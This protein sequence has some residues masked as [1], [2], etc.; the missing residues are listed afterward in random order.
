MNRTAPHLFLLIAG[1][2]AFAAAP[3]TQPS[4]Q[5][6]TRKPD[7]VVAVKAEAAQTVFDITCPSGIGAATIVPQAQ[8]GDW[9]DVVVVRLHLTGLESLILSKGD[10]SIAA[11]VSTQPGH[12]RRLRLSGSANAMP[13]ITPDSPFWM[14]IKAFDA[15]GKLLDPARDL[16]PKVGYFEMIVPKTLLEAGGKQAREL[17]IEWV[18]FFRN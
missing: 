15:Q 16:P 14:E 9:P 10:K 7:D 2:A 1:L 11:E 8:Q 6:T 18:D 17:K 12:A 3:A 13:E 4:F 5:I